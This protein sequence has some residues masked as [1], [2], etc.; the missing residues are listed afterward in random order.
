MFWTTYLFFSHG[1]T[2]QSDSFNLST[3]LCKTS[4]FQ[5][6]YFNRIVKLWNYVCKLAPPT[7]FCS[8]N[9]FQLFVRKRISKGVWSQLPL[10]L[11]ASP[12]MLMPLLIH[13][14]FFLVFLWMLVYDF[15]LILGLNPGAVP[16]MG[17]RPLAPAPFGSCLF[18]LCYVIYLC[19]VPNKAV[20]KKLL[21]FSTTCHWFQLGP[22]TCSDSIRN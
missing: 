6:P 3:P 17:L 9:A 20:K 15:V 12:N 11:D 22:E 2:R 14:S 21:I 18:L 1:R 4:T 7:S 16:R 10:H 19:G 5:A 13:I 8:P